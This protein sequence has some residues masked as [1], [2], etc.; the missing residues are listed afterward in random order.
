M[1]GML[2]M[3]ARFDQIWTRFWLDFDKIW[4]KYGERQFYPTFSILALVKTTHYKGKT[5]Y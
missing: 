4:S 3:W 5:M 1:V 2:G